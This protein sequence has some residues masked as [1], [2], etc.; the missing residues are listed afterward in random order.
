MGPISLSD[1]WNSLIPLIS[2][3][4]CSLV[5]SLP[6][7]TRNVLCASLVCKKELVR[8]WLDEAAEQHGCALFWHVAVKSPV[9][10]LRGAVLLHTV[11]WESAAVC[12]CL[13]SYWL[14]LALFCPRVCW[15]SCSLIPELRILGLSLMSIFFRLR[16][17]VKSSWADSK[18]WETLKLV[19]GEKG[20][21]ESLIY[22]KN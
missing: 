4:K 13:C 15:P 20:R 5:L 9:L 7:G 12:A 21:W 18:S 14:G 8:W 19:W 3:R 16:A 1:V 11:T 2:K 22:K 10:V 6:C 17:W